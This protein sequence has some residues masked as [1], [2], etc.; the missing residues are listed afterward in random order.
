MRRRPK[1]VDV[2]VSHN[3]RS[4]CCDARLGVVILR[5]VKCVTVRRVKDFAPEAF[6]VMMRL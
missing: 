2:M 4:S 6:R 1:K 5:F 3:E